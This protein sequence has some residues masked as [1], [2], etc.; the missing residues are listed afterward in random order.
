V[1]LS[2][3]LEIISER[4]VRAASQ[5]DLEDNSNYTYRQGTS[6]FDGRKHLHEWVNACVMP[7]RRAYITTLAA[8]GLAG[9]LGHSPDSTTASTTETGT[10]ASSTTSRPAVTIEAATVQ[11]AYRH[12]QNVDWNAIRTADGQFVFVTVDA[13]DADP[14]PGRDT[15]TLVTTGET[16]D[17]VAIE[18]N[19]PVGLDVSGEPYRPD[20]QDG[21]PQ[22]W[23]L[24]DVP[25]HLDT[26]PSLRLERD[27]DSWEW[28]LN[29]EKATAPPP[30]WEWTVSAPETVAPNETFDI[31]VSAE[32]VGD[33]PGTFRGAVN[34][35][36]PL[37]RPKGFDIM[38]DPGESGDAT[39]SASSDDADP[40][41][42]LEYGVRTPTE[43]SSVTVTV[44]SESSSTATSTE[45]TS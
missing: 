34:F 33:G 38:L 7:S 1:C 20:Q 6:W 17:P 43:K 31:T 45:S 22:G 41:Q 37:Y 14:T 27:T 36:Y 28:E 21:D 9:C 12:I 39:V 40:G 26:A 32:N 35:S 24:F 3:L 10:T 19:Y 13:R 18:H 15:F 25:A 23:V 44:A 30:A 42:E 2:I 29:T 5:F 11:Y 8:T 16:F 4:Q